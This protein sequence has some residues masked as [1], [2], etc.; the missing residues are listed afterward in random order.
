MNIISLLFSVAVYI[1]LLVF[2]REVKPEYA[3]VLSV[4]FG[5]FMLLQAFPLANDILEYIKT[6]VVPDGDLLYMKIL[7]KAV[8]VSFV[9]QYVSEICHEC[10]FDAI[11]S[12]T[13]LLGKIYMTALSLP[14]I[15][16]IFKAVDLY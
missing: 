14:L 7:Y 10:G 13:E 6:F 15:E 5:V 16:Q 3:T 12:K 4:L 8:G 1:L 9:C 11:A 2:I